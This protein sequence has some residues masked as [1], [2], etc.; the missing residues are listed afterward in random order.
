M[1]P[2]LNYAQTVNSLVLVAMD[3]IINVQNVI[4]DYLLR[5][6]LLLL[7]VTVCLV[8]HQTQSQMSVLYQPLLALTPILVWILVHVNL[9]LELVR[10]NVQPDIL[11]IDV[12]LLHSNLPNHSAT[13]T[14]ELFQTV[15]LV[16]VFNAPQGNIQTTIPNLVFPVHSHVKHAKALPYV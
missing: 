13:V 5:I 12:D 4:Q 7:D 11:V 8:S 9:V 16:T 15:V 6:D 14:L 2:L 3:S 1:T 10:V